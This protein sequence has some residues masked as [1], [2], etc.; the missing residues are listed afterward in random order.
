MIIFRQHLP[1]LARVEIFGGLRYDVA[2]VTEAEIV[3]V[4]MVG[5]TAR[6]Y[7]AGL[8]DRSGES[9]HTRYYGH[10]AIFSISPVYITDVISIAGNAATRAMLENL[11]DNQQVFSLIGHPV[12]AKTLLD[13]IKE[14]EAS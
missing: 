4:P 9:V 8:A 10:S 2:L 12:A 3:G 1:M 6:M 13:G 11:R 14:S 5:V 7:G